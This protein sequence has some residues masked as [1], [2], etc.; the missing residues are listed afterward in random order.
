M[1][2][3]AYIGTGGCIEE[4][5]GVKA[6]RG[7]GGH[8]GLQKNG[9][10]RRCVEERVGAKVRRGTG[11]RH[12]EWMVTNVHRAQVGAKAQKNGWV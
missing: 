1:G 12:E 8:E 5:V 11:G 3:K 2:V 6:R 7:T 10:A 4:W 9:W